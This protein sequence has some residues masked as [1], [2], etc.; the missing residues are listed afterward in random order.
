MGCNSQIKSQEDCWKTLISL[1]LKKSESQ[2]KKRLT[3]NPNDKLSQLGMAYTQ[4]ALDNPNW[5]K[6]LNKFTEDPDSSWTYGHLA[7]AFKHYAEGTKN[8]EFSIDE[9]KAMH[10]GGKFRAEKGFE[11][12]EGE[13]QNL[14]P[15]GIWHIYNLENELIREHNFDEEQ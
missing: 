2:F 4:C 3:N 5:M 15:I 7:V 14:N 11:I 1:D 6:S 8:I 10:L 12:I 9:F 13:Y